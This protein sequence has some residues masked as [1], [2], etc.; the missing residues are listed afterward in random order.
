M[1]ALNKQFRHHE[2][3]HSSNLF[4]SFLTCSISWHQSTQLSVP[5]TLCYRVN[6]QPKPLFQYLWD[7]STTAD[8]ADGPRLNLQAA[9]SPVPSLAGVQQCKDG[10]CLSIS[11]GGY[12]TVPAYNFGQH[13]QLS[14]A[15]W[16]RPL[17]GS[18][19]YARLFD[20]GNG[21]EQDN[22]VLGRYDTTDRLVFSVWRSQTE[23][24]Y[25]SATGLWIS[26][27]WRHLAWTISSTRGTEAAHSMY[28]DGALMAFPTLYHPANT[29][30]RSNYIGKS[31]WN[32]GATVANIDSFKIYSSLLTS[33]HI[34]NLMQVKEF[35]LCNGEQL[36]TC[37]T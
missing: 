30:L 17:D 5:L 32:H 11:S 36:H 13:L 6:P 23:N 18:G 20:F 29:V 27:Q 12:L 25:C 10:S 7:T 16:Y 8:S 33:V 4:N 1:H 14:F 9:G 21:P 34:A 19:P 3:G 22:I 31:N 37:V 15:M 35:F 28:I 24:I 2:I 26:N